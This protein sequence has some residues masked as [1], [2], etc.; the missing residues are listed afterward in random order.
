VK[1]VKVIREDIWVE[2]GVDLAL[3]IDMLVNAYRDLY[4]TAV[5]VSGDGD[6]APLLT[7]IQRLRKKVEVAAFESEIGT[8]LRIRADRYIALG[9]LSPQ[10]HLDASVNKNGGQ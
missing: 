6:F 10:I 3:A 7:E 1:P 5:L 4:D 8:E 2:K 9:N